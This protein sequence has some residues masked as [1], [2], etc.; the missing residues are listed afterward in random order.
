MKV[1]KLDVNYLEHHWDLRDAS[2]YI[3]VHS[4]SNSTRKLS[5]IIVASS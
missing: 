3:H 4:N 5:R 2:K 1:E